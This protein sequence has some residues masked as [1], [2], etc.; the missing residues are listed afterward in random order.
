MYI[1]CVST[2]YV[3][4]VWD[5]FVQKNIGRTTWTMNNLAKTHKPH[6]PKNQQWQ[7][8]WASGEAEQE[9]GLLISKKAHPLFNLSTPGRVNRIGEVYLYVQSRATYLLQ[10]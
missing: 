9:K 3:F 1:L 10:G 4:D 7:Y 8:S 2:P 5:C 6:G